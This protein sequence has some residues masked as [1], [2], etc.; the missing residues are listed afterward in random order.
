[1]NAASEHKNTLCRGRFSGVYVGEDADVPIFGY[2]AHGCLKMLRVKI[3]DLDDLPGVLRLKKTAE[4]T[5]WSKDCKER[6]WSVI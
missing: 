4:D 1:V 6:K 2:V 5:S 3:R